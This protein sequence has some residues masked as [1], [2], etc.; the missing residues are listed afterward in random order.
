MHKEVNNGMTEMDLFKI[1]FESIL[2]SI[3]KTKLHSLLLVKMNIMS[4]Y[5][6]AVL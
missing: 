4:T 1:F 5:S 6:N 2:I 3:K